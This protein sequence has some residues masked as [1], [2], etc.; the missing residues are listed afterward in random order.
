MTAKSP[1]RGSTRIRRPKFNPLPGHDP[2]YEKQQ[3]IS[4]YR[5]V[6]IAMNKPTLQDLK[7]AIGGKLLS[8]PHSA[9]SSQER[10]NSV[11]IGAVSIDSRQ[12]KA[13][14]VFWALDGVHH[15]GSDF[16]DEAFAAGALVAVVGKAVDVPDG[17]WAIV[18]KNTQRALWQWA[19][20][21][22]RRFGGTMIAVTG[23]VGK[24]TTRQMIHTVL[25]NR[26]TGTASPRNY[27]NH[28]GVPLSLMAVEP[29]HDYAVLELGA[30][31][32]GEIAGLAEL[33]KPNVGVVTHVGD[34]HLGGFGSR[35]AIAEAKG[36]LL[37]ALPADGRAILVDD[38]YVRQIAR[39]SKAPITW[40]GRRGD[41]DIVADEV[42]SAGGRL[43]FRVEGCQFDVPVWGRHNIGAALA[44]VAVGR[45]FGMDLSAIAGALTKFDP[46]PMRCEVIQLRGATIINDTYNASPTAMRAALELLRDFDSNGRRIV[47]CGDMVELGKESARLHFELGGEIVSLCGADLVIACG[48][49]ARH[50]VDGA[51]KAG[52]PGGR[53]I[54]C[55]TPEAALPY[56]GQA[57]QPGDVVL[58]KGSRAMAMERVVEALR[59]YPQRRSA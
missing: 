15:N 27:N 50:V 52:M 5:L 28:I 10:E 33:T 48:Q 42:T 49:Q 35:R 11:Q 45:M 7:N 24:T 21:A 23:S 43:G 31:S 37:R 58:V 4:K 2:A 26:L 51:R 25:G 41:C 56:L 59:Q 14:D 18:V 12:I 38:P 17:C 32:P 30:S 47:V 20:W 13:G 39:R 19:A 46:V 1:A 8:V 55:E 40:V 54:P 53:A 44:A 9:H 16:A 57:I 6:S 29:Q 36:E 3:T 34:A 22:R